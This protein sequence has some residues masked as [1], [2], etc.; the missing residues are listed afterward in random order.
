MMI[1]HPSCPLSHRLKNF[2]AGKATLRVD[3]QR[4]AKKRV[5]AV[6]GGL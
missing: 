3:G 6:M 2:F 5:L 4:V 1:G